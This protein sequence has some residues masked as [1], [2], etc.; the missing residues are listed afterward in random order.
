MR[1]VIIYIDGPLGTGVTPLP[2]LEMIAEVPTIRAHNIWLTSG[3][4]TRRKPRL[5]STTMGSRP[6]RST[7]GRLSLGNTRVGK[8]GPADSSALVP[9]RPVRENTMNDGPT[10]QV[11][12]RDR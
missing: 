8:R 4:E 1:I 3:D 6:V 5:N 9:K 11:N 10:L 7:F 2:V 12:G